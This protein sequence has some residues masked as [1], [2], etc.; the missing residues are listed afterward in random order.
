MPLGCR[1]DLPPRLAAQDILYERHGSDGQLPPIDATVGKIALR[2]DVRGGRGEIEPRVAVREFLHRQFEEP[3]DHCAPV[4][5]HATTGMA[6]P[7]GRLRQKIPRRDRAEC[8]RAN[9]RD[10]PHRLLA[11]R[12]DDGLIHQ[13]TGGD[14]GAGLL[15]RYVNPEIGQVGDVRNVWRKLVPPALDRPLAVL[16]HRHH[17]ARSRPCAR[18]V[19]EPQ[20]LR[21]Q[22]TTLGFLN[23]L[24]VQRRRQGRAALAEQSCTGDFQIARR[25]FLRSGDMPRWATVAIG[26]PLVAEKHDRRLEPLHFVKVH[27]PH[28]TTSRRIDRNRV[29]VLPRKFI[30]HEVV[31]P[32]DH[33]LHRRQQGPLGA[34][35]LDERGNRARR[36]TTTP[37]RPAARHRGHQQQ[38]RVVGD[39]FEGGRERQRAR[40][41]PPPPERLGRRSQTRGEILDSETFRHEQPPVDPSADPAE[42]V[43][44]SVTKA[45][46]GSSQHGKRRHR[47]VGVGDHPQAELKQGKILPAVGTLAARDVARQAGGIESLRVGRKLTRVPR[48]DHEILGPTGRILV[49]RSPGHGELVVDC[50]TDKRRDRLGFGL[51]VAGAHP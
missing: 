49:H 30:C 5:P 9:R 29:E 19:I 17:Q 35:S 20:I 38:T 32:V 24:P 8:R 46:H 39:P 18:D 6:N 48:D 7:L 45:E 27:H 3:V 36:G 16:E 21:L 41:A 4:L 1:F 15:G 43:E 50:L 2:N 37:A 10:T 51:D 12:T 13:W 33:V 22:I 11:S 28:G 44:I 47:V 34:D 42:G 25:P 23:I 26:S 31:D 14:V 40:D